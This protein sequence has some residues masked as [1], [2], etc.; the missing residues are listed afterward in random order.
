MQYGLDQPRQPETPEQAHEEVRE[1]AAQE[2]DFI[3]VWVDSAGG[4][5]PRIG[6]EIL[7]A[8]VDEASR[9]GIPVVAHLKSRESMDELL[10]LGVTD[11]LHSLEDQD[12][13]DSEFVRAL[14]RHHASFA[15]LLSKLA[16]RSAEGC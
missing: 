9:Q 1:V 11:F 12:P 6:S 3:K 14:K 5:I 2:V 13:E 16:E 15:P 4:T 7:Q 10:A 8:I